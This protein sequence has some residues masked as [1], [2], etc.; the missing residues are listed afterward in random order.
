MRVQSSLKQKEKKE[1]YKESI[2]EGEMFSRTAKAQ[3][4]SKRGT[5][6]WGTKR[7]HAWGLR[8]RTCQ[9]WRGGEV[10]WPCIAGRFPVAFEASALC[11]LTVAALVET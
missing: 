10:C 5:V 1:R 9:E 4:K 8:C 7:A 2:D 11:N 3:Y 6:R